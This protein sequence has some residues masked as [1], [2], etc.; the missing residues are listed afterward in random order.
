MSPE[1][2]VSLCL[3]VPFIYAGLYTLT[4]P[5]S[6]IRVVNK[7]MADAHRLEA[8]TLL[9]DLFAEPRPI[10]DSLRTRGWLRF[11]GLAIMAA[12]LFRLYSL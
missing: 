1:S 2:I 4:D 8:S 3:L 10:V 7:L 12:G 5:S 9:G 6:S 11:A